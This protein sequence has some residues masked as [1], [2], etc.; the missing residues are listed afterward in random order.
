M[1]IGRN[2]M[3][4]INQAFQDKLITMDIINIVPSKVLSK[5]ITSGRKY[6]SIFASIKSIGLVE[7]LVITFR[8]GK[9]RL[10]DGHIR[11]HILKTLGIKQTDCLISTDDEGYT[12]NRHVS[13]ITNIQERNMIMRAIDN[14]VSM[15]KIANALGIDVKT[16]KDKKNLLENIH[17]DVV[18]MLK[19][20]KIPIKTFSYL[21]RMKDIRQIEVTQFMCSIGNF[22]ATTAYHFW[23]DTKPEMLRVQP[24]RRN[25]F[26]IEKLASLENATSRIT[27]EYR[28]IY[29]DFGKCV[30]RLQIAQAWVRSIF[31]NATAWRFLKNYYPDISRRFNELVD[32]TDL[33][34]LKSEVD[35]DA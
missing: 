1:E 14:G 13:H 25:E 3:K 20:R 33:N 26:D 29:K 27:K 34:D 17:P 7:P 21:R 32:L 11:L 23:A 22:S 10:L 16:L 4:N 6:R 19:T 9:V 31:T 35:V 2:R 18:E 12:Y 15:E 8:D 24:P 5:F 28:L 30:A